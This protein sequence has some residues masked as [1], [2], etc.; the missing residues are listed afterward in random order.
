LLVKLKEYFGTTRLNRI[1][2]E[3]I[4]F[5]REDRGQ[6][7]GNAMLNAEI[8]VLRRILKRGKLWHQFSD[9]VAAA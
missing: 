9:D 1:T 4:I 2:G 5:Y 3:Q 8:G 6:S 7:C